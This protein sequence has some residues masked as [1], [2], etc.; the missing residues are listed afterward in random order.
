MKL[1]YGQDSVHAPVFIRIENEVHQ[2]WE[3]WQMPVNSHSWQ[4]EK[5][6]SSRPDRHDLETTCH[7][8]SVITPAE[9]PP[10]QPTNGVSIHVS[11]CLSK[12][13]G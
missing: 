7:N 5:V 13:I 9:R 11:H 6:Q 1:N 2:L 10:A 4:T 12:I 8:L 3:A